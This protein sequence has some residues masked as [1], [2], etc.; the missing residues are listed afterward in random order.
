MY[1]LRVI[2]YILVLHV[3]A[4]AGKTLNFTALV[5]RKDIRREAYYQ[6]LFSKSNKRKVHKLKCSVSLA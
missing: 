4:A 5:F 3:I 1:E 6:F 2:A